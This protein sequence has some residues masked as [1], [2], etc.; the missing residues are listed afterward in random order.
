MRFDSDRQR[1]AVFANLNRFSDE[2]RGKKTAVVVGGFKDPYAVANSFVW[3]PHVRNVAI[4]ASNTKG[5]SE[6]YV[7]GKDDKTTEIIARSVQMT[8]APVRGIILDSPFDETLA[9]PMFVMMGGKKVEK[10]LSDVEVPS[11][12]YSNS[13]KKNNELWLKVMETRSKRIKATPEDIEKYSAM[14]DFFP[15]FQSQ[16]RHDLRIYPMFDAVGMWLDSAGSVDK[17]TYNVIK[18]AARL[19]LS[20]VGSMTP[21]KK[22]LDDVMRNE[23]GEYMDTVE[24]DK[25]IKS[26]GAEIPSDVYS[27][28]PGGLSDGEYRRLQETIA[29]QD[30]KRNLAQIQNAQDI[31]KGVISKPPV[32]GEGE[33]FVLYSKKRPQ[34][35]GSKW[36][37]EKYVHGPRIMQPKEFAFMKTVEPEDKYR[38]LEGGD[39]I[40]DHLAEGSKLVIGKL[41]EGDWAVQSVLTPR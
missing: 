20:E 4:L 13:P 35:I 40:P 8:P 10:D 12:V 6:I 16:V 7:E 2:P 21:A 11:D 24:L 32:Q 3:H 39:K 19:Y 17:A 28:S 14:F 29:L 1:K 26:G 31:E 15:E 34:A 38:H 33:G 25:L 22:S 37:G 23:S 27:N 9:D 18:D 41:R 36:K 5:L 30:A